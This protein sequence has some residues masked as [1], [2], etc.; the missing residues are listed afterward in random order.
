MKIQNK[1][2][3]ENKLR[4]LD[5]VKWDRYYTWKQGVV[6]YGWIEREKDQYKDF[7][8]VEFNTRQKVVVRF[9]TSS[10]KYTEK[11]AETLDINHS[12]CFRV[13]DKFAIDN[14]IELNNEKKGDEKSE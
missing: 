7:I 9:D 3:V 2:W 10:E 5:F 6:V 12:E 14:K 1:A 4:N 8:S 13:E 11:I